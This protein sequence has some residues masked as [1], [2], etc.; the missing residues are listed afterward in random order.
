[1]RCWAFVLLV[2]SAGM[3]SLGTDVLGQEQKPRKEPPKQSK[4]SSSG[5][6]SAAR[7]VPPG[8][9]ALGYTKCVI[10]ERPVAEDVTAERTGEHKWFS[11]QYWMQQP[12]LDHYQNARGKLAISVNG[13]VVSNSRD[14]KSAKIPYLPG[15]DGFYVEFDV[16][17][18]DDHKDHFPALFLMPREHCWSKEDHYPGDPEGFERWME[19]D[20][21]EGGFGPGVNGTVF[22][23]SGIHPDYKNVGNP[24]RTSNVPVQR[25][26]M[27]TFGAAYDP[28]RPAVS[29]WLNG[30]FLM[31]AG[32]P[33]VPEVAKKQ[34]F[35]L[36][37]GAQTFGKGVPYTMYLGG[38]RAFVSPTSKLPEVDVPII[39]VKKD[40]GKLTLRVS[41]PD[42]DVQILT[43]EGQVEDARLVEKKSESIDVAP[44][45]HQLKVWKNGFHL[46]TKNFKIDAGGKT[47]ITAKLE[48]VVKQPGGTTASQENRDS[49]AFRKWV[50]DVWGLPGVKQLEHVSKKLIELN[51]G[52]YGKLTGPLHTHSVPII[53]EHGQVIELMVLVDY[54]SD[55]SPVRVLDQLIVLKCA[56]SGPGKGYLSDLSPLKGLRLTNLDLW[57]TQVKDLSPLEGMPIEMLNVG[58]TPVSD[59]SP[60]KQLSRQ[61]RWG[62]EPLKFTLHCDNTPISDLSPLKGMK[63]KHLDCW[64]TRVK[65]LSALEGMPLEFLN[66]SSTPVSDL[67]P[68][69]GM[70][71]RG[72]IFTPKNITAGID[73]I[74]QMKS[75]ESI[76]VDG[77]AMLKPD[78]FWK[79][80]DAGEFNKSK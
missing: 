22:S 25:T 34:N 38:V 19:L 13:C 69:K 64:S 27:N 36:I 23:S 77:G 45:K 21:D 76:G 6:Q 29:W 42:V 62:P 54:V 71:L 35:Y 11:G 15:A 50:E 56:G 26:K 53:S 5:K 33:Y 79:K 10:D 41:E 3:F 63:L 72:I 78:E 68:L 4:Q 1:M 37:I 12:T 44:G 51:P 28:K 17:L 60:L 32:E 16:Q 61:S 74:R 14:M 59:L 47:P 48:P 2:L 75:I 30:K 24:N 80:F 58:H 52:F 40:V 8:A 66:C 43:D 49:P 65:D 9:K 7:K 73:V 18:S 67:S 31:E 20:V 55:I 57:G 46:L 39:K 70:P